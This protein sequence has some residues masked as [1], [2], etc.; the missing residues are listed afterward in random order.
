MKKIYTLLIALVIALPAMAGN[1][2]IGIQPNA[3]APPAIERTA[4][5]LTVKNVFGWSDALEVDHAKP[6]ENQTAVSVDVTNCHGFGP[7]PG[8]LTLTYEQSKTYEGGPGYGFNGANCVNP[9]YSF[10]VADLAVKNGDANVSTRAV[11]TYKIGTSTIR[12]VLKIP[13]LPGLLTYASC[14]PPSVC[15]QS[16]EFSG[17]WNGI[18]G[19]SSFIAFVNKG[20]EG[21]VRM[22]ITDDSTGTET[23]ETVYLHSGDTFYEMTTKVA[24][25]RLRMSIPPLGFGCPGCTSEALTPKIYAVLFRG[26][27]GAGVAE[28]I[29]PRQTFSLAVP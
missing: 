6:G 25:G 20:P 16:Y 2:Y 11:Y 8:P 22:T 26:Y 10:D 28:A 4:H 12:D 18:D 21:N 29:I 13:E 7:L 14:T 1:H 9:S 23:T 17:V 19:R 24:Y 27:K 3:T 15:S 5:V